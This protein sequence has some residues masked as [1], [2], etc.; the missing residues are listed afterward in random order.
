MS[1]L[2]EFLMARI[3]EDEWDARRALG[4]DMGARLKD[5]AERVAHQHGSV[6][7]PDEPNAADRLWWTTQDV[8]QWLAPYG[9]AR[10]LD[11]CEAKQ[12]L[13][14][15]ALVWGEGCLDVMARY[16]AEVYAAHPDYR[17]EWRP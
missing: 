5:Q 8:V 2:T 17:E 11:V 15:E 16:M 14:D 13:L 7:P 12:H 3:D 1:D 6:T 10:V 4:L 9:P